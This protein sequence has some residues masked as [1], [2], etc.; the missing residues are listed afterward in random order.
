M[1]KQ[2]KLTAYQKQ[3]VVGIVTLHFFLVSTSITW[4]EERDGFYRIN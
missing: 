2:R 3:S 4:E 1:I